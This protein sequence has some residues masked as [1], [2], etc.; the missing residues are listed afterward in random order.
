ML[1]DYLFSILPPSPNA[2][3]L[4][5]AV[6]GHFAS[7]GSK[8]FDERLSRWAPDAE[9]EDPVGSP[10][11]I[12]HDALRAFWEPVARLN[13]SGSVKRMVI[14]GDKASY[15][16]EITLDDGNADRARIIGLGNAHIDPTGRIT[17]MQ[18]F[19]DASSVS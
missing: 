10:P 12:G 13:I 18:A 4:K 7:I 15:E 19:F 2:N 14:C 8:D 1:K 11:V 3:L 17:K 5:A 9:L 6:E 16:F